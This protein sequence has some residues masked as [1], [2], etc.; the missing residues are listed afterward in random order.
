MQAVGERGRI[1]PIYLNN[2]KYSR[3]DMK[4]AEQLPTVESTNDRQKRIVEAAKSKRKDQI[5]TRPARKL[6][7]AER[8]LYDQGRRFDVEA[9]GR[10]SSF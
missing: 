6:T 8:K 9:A 1:Y 3:V 4:R 7:N 5:K 10:L 2:M